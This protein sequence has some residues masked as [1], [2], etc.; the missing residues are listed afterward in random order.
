MLKFIKQNSS[1]E[2]MAVTFAIVK[3]VQTHVS[4]EPPFRSEFEHFEHAM[5]AT[6]QQPVMGVKGP[7][8]LM[9]LSKQL[10][11]L[12]LDSRNNAKS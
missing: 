11:A 6:H 7:S 9:K 5:A 1:T 3:M 10:M 12:W 8:P 2:N 4:P